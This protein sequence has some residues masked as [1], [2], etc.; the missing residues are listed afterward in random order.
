LWKNRTGFV[1]KMGWANN[2]LSWLSSI[3]S[4]F[5]GPFEF[6]GKAN[7]TPGTLSDPA[8]IGRLFNPD[9]FKVAAFSPLPDDAHQCS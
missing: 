9:A 7:R 4:I 2:V 6:I 8:G 5:C 1:Y 3:A